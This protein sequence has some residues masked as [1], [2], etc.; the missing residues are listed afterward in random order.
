MVKDENLNDICRDGLV[1][2]LLFCKVYRIRV[3][4]LVFYFLFIIKGKWFY[5]FKC[6]LKEVILFD[7]WM[8]VDVFLM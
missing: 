5:L 6:V 3:I 1:R 4:N 7:W 8:I 2:W